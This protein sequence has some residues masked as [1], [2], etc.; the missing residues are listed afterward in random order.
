MHTFTTFDHPKLGDII[1][2]KQAEIPLLRNEEKGKRPFFGNE[3]KQTVSNI[4]FHVSLLT[5][6]HHPFPS[7]DFYM[8]F[9]RSISQNIKFHSFL[10]L[11][12]LLSRVSRSNTIT[13]AH[14]CISETLK[15]GPILKFGVFCCFIPCR[16]LALIPTFAWL[17]RSSRSNGGKAELKAV[18]LDRTKSPALYGAPP[19]TVDGAPAFY[20]APTLLN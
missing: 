14:F 17:A 3:Q 10:L 18:V 5:W 16:P 6:V 9:T 20:G 4:Y 13:M 7:L 2:Q 11:K 8:K 12:S 19:S 1:I 15:T